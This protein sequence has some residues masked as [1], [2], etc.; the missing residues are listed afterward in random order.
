MASLECPHCLKSVYVGESTTSN[1][2]SAFPYVVLVHYV[3]QDTRYH[4][5]LEKIVCPACSQF[6]LTLAYSDEVDVNHHHGLHYR[7]PSKA[8]K[9][10][11]EQH[12]QI[13]PR[14]SGR[15]PI[16]HEVPEHFR[17]DYL[18]A[19]LVL[20]DSPRASAALSRGC[21]QLILRE[22]IGAKG[23]NLQHE[24]EWVIESGNLPS[25]ITD[26]LDIPRRIGNRAAHPSFVD[27][28]RISDVEPWE[29]EWC[30]EVIEAL[31]EY[32]FVVPARNRERLERLERLDQ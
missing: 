16:P 26:L 7:G 21:L 27:A 5:W 31:Y 13:W 8:P 22:Q 18:E 25:S 24:I 6:I 12:I 17:S 19:C 4:W 14:H 2:D 23:K 32:L 28:T 10:E 1:F 3:G 20:A 11:T 29:A 30:L 15:P 9:P